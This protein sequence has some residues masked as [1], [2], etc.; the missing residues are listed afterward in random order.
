MEGNGRPVRCR[1]LVARRSASARPSATLSSRSLAPP[2]PACQNASARGAMSL[3]SVFA[4]VQL[5]ESTNN[6]PGLNVQVED[7]AHAYT[8]QPGCI[9]ARDCVPFQN[10]DF[11]FSWVLPWT[12]AWATA[13]RTVDAQRPTWSP[14]PALKTVATRPSHTRQAVASA[15]ASGRGRKTG[16]WPRRA[17]RHGRVRSHL[18]CANKSSTIVEIIV[19][20]PPSLGHSAFDPKGPDHAFHQPKNGLEIASSW[21]NTII[22]NTAAGIFT[23]STPPMTATFH[24]F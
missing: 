18:E 9:Q 19:V 13:R 3:V 17:V 16:R 2:P 11:Y 24:L 22:G 1:L 23:L 6:K 4:A 12:R 7:G 8:F 21:P 15:P 20:R 10:L 5:L 14:S